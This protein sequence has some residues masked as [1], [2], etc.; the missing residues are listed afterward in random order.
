M[1]QN[2][3]AKKRI[4][5]PV[6][7]LKTLPSNLKAYGGF[8]WP[9]S[10]YVKCPDFDPKR[11]IG[12]GFHGLLLGQ[13]N[14]KVLSRSASAKW[15]VLEVDSKKL[16][17]LD[18]K[19]K[20]EEC[21]VLV[22]GT[23]AEATSYLYYNSSTDCIHGLTLTVGSRQIITGGGFCNITCGN[24]NSIFV[25]DG[26]TVIGGDFCYITAL[27]RS[28]ASGGTETVIHANAM[29][30]LATGPRGRFIWYSNDEFQHYTVGTSRDAAN[31]IIQPNTFYRLNEDNKPVVAI[32]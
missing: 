27:G 22:C 16:I 4:K 2:L 17:H 6:L 8:Q 13:G 1:P 30:K 19:V 10:G 25:E 29:G 31:Q 24:F 14:S 20:F 5:N 18:G 32:D 9:S 12:G 11:A 15:L 7:V 23:Q 28:T 21:N 3:P 26:S